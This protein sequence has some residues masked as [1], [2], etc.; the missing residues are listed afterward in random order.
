M[1]FINLLSE[2]LFV[3]PNVMRTRR[4]FFHQFL[5]IRFETPSFYKMQ[6]IYYHIVWLILITWY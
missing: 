3:I 1:I 2:I 5:S 4:M 6:I